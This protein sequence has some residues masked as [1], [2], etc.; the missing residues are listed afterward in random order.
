M[1]VLKFGG[2]SVAN[3]ERIAR[4]AALVAEAASRGRTAVVVSALAGVTDAL[5]AAADATTAGGGWREAI[6]ALDRRHFECL[7]CLAADGDRGR[8]ASAMRARLADLRSMIEGAGERR[9][10]TPRERDSI[11]AAGERLA[12]PLVATALRSAGVEADAVDASALVLTDSRFGEAVVNGPATNER[13]KRFLG[14]VATR[15]VPVVTGFIGADTAG[16]T[17]TLGRGGSDYTASL[18]GAA[19][20]ASVVEIWTDVDGVLTG[21]PRLLPNARTVPQLTY[22]EAAELAFFGAK[23]LHRATM[24]PLAAVGIPIVVRNTFASSGGATRISSRPHAS[25]PRPAAVTAVEDVE[26]LVATPGDGRR[27]TSDAVCREVADSGVE[28]IAVAQASAD[29]TASLV[30]PAAGAD[31]AVA[32]LRRLRVVDRRGGL[33]LVVLVGHHLGRSPES[34]ANSLTGLVVARVPLIGVWA[35]ISPH[36][37]AVLVERRGLPDALATLH[38]HVLAPSGLAE[39]QRDHTVKEGPRRAGRGRDGPRAIGGPGDRAEAR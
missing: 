16:H 35:G 28:P 17:T 10:C 13:I 24:D 26:L 3:A 25:P 23:V 20:H 12:A 39:L 33:A 36:S 6:D 14:T 2:T 38:G 11:L 19:V 21:P 31:R 8:A 1:R 30:V 29:G 18:V 5:A 34:A 9:R 22:E 4:V 15:T 32:G 27:R 37:L 7:D